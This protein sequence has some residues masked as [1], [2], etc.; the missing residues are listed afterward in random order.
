[1]SVKS[2]WSIVSL[3]A[4]VSLFISCLDDLSTTAGVAGSSCNSCGC[5]CGQ[6]WSLGTGPAGVAEVLVQAKA[7]HLVWQGM[8]HFG[9]APVG[10]AGLAGQVCRRMPVGRSSA[11][12]IDGECQK[13][14]P[15]A[16]GQLGR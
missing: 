10:W 8:R 9:G 2:I 3:K 15:Q 13:W 16:P 5:V 11:S 7:T 1:M 4:S 12:K 6:D 14:C